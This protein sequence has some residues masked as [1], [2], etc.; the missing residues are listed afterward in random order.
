MTGRRVLV[1][2]PDADGAGHLLSGGG[3]GCVQQPRGALRRAV[4]PGTRSH[5]RGIDPLELC[6][7]PH[8]R[9]VGGRD[10][11]VE[12]AGKIAAIT[13]LGTDKDRAAPLA[14]NGTNSV[15]ERRAAAGNAAEQESIAVGAAAAA[16]RQRDL[17]Q[18]VDVLY[19]HTAE[20]PPRLS[21]SRHA[22]AANAGRDA[23]VG[24]GIEHR[25][26]PT[27]IGGSPTATNGAVEAIGRDCGGHRQ[28]RGPCPEESAEEHG[29]D[30]NR[31]RDA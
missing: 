8:D 22:D 3:V 11:R 28:R 4:E 1:A 26:V 14:L 19:R 23:P 18:Q 5:R 31:T 24:R 20:H 9:S 27:L 21:S 12:V 25:P 15:I 6:A 13:A 10:A 7:K 30:G 2:C 16:A 17:R 29:C